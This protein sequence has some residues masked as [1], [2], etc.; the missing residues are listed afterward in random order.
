[1][2]FSQQGLS[3]RQTNLL[4]A[5]C[6]K[7]FAQSDDFFEREDFCMGKKTVIFLEFSFGMQ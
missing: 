6:G 3:A 2:P 5:V 4:H 7:D 1:M